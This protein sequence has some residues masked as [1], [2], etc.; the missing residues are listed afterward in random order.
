MLPTGLTYSSLAKRFIPFI[1]NC[2]C[3]VDRR[4]FR[5]SSKRVARRDAGMRRST[6]TP[7]KSSATRCRGARSWRGPAGFGA[8]GPGSGDSSAERVRARGRTCARSLDLKG[9]P[10][11][12]ATS[13]ATV[14]SRLHRSTRGRRPGRAS[15]NDPRG[16]RTRTAKAHAAGQSRRG[17]GSHACL[18]AGVG[19]LGEHPLREG[20]PASFPTQVSGHWEEAREPDWISHTAERSAPYLLQSPYIFYR[21]GSV[22]SCRRVYWTRSVT[23]AVRDLDDEK[24]Q[25]SFLDP[26]RGAKRPPGRAEER[27]VLGRLVAC[28]HVEEPFRRSLPDAR[29]I[30]AHLAQ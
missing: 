1:A 23:G 20:D 29:E 12:G 7:A 13:V 22:V 11:T 24:H 26:R 21:S 15:R 3:G 9:N 30:H 27:E 2:T 16:E 17:A 25:R 4:V 5:S 28:S 6:P 19:S 10:Q 14:L 18:R 8:S